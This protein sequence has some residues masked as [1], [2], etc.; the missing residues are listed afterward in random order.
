MVATCYSTYSLDIGDFGFVVWEVG[1][2]VGG[3]GS[4]QS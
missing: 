1:V 4:G 2:G 3:V